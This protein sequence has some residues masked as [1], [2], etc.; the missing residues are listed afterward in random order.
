M[1][2]AGSSVINGAS[3]IVKIGNNSIKFEDPTAALNMDENQWNALVQQ[4]AI[5]F[6]R[7]NERKKLEK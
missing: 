3:N 2:R 7:E 4:N 5:D 6:H 1:S